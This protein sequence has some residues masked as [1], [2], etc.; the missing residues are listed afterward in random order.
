[1]A[2]QRWQK[3]VVKTPGAGWNLGWEG[4]APAFTSL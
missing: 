2:N 1:M 3:S 4:P